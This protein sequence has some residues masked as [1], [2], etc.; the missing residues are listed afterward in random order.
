MMNLG[1]PDWR[2]R[3]SLGLE[4]APEPRKQMM[5]AS[6]SIRGKAGRG[7]NKDEI[8]LGDNSGRICDLQGCPAQF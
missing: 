2:Q 4:V 6:G 5:V 7:E 8:L 1:E 3:G